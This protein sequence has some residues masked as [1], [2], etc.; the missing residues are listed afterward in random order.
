MCP[1]PTNA[2]DSLLGEDTVRIEPVERVEHARKVDPEEAKR[3][4]ASAETHP[5]PDRNPFLDYVREFVKPDDFIEY[6]VEGVQ[7]EVL[8]N[9]RNGLYVPANEL[10]LH[11]KTILEARQL[12]WKLLERTTESIAESNWQARTV[13]IVHGRG[14]RSNPPAIMKSFVR[15]CLAMYPHVLA[16]VTA[17]R[18]LGGTGAM[19]VLLKKSPGAREHTRS[20]LGLKNG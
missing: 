4:Q 17:P 10:D 18:H 11:H 20:L 2:L 1:E 7:P 15:E 12:I 14:I 6:K 9:L 13:R 5:T 19:F 16:Y 3:R 8:S